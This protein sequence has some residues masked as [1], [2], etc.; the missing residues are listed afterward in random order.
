MAFV[1]CKVD[2]ATPADLV[3]AKANYLDKPLDHLDVPLYTG[4]AQSSHT[5]RVH[6][7]SPNIAHTETEHPHE[8]CAHGNVPAL[9]GGDQ[10]VTKAGHMTECCD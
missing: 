10:S 8:P 4:R 7:P 1:S 6:L 5:G 3:P 2:R 9:N